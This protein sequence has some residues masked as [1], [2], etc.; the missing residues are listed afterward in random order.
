MCDLCL[1]NMVDS[2]HRWLPLLA[3]LLCLKLPTCFPF[4][5]PVR[6]RN[7][8]RT[9]LVA[10]RSIPENYWK[11]LG[12][13]PGS[14]VKEVK[15]IYRQRAKKEHPDVNKS[16][17]HWNVGVCCRMPMES[18]LIRCIVKN[19]KRSKRRKLKELRNEFA[20]AIPPTEGGQSHPHLRRPASKGKH[21]NGLQV[22]GI[23][24]VILCKKL[25]SFS[26]DLPMEMQMQVMLFESR[27]LLKKNFT[28]SKKNW[29]NCGRMKPNIWSLLNSSNAVVRRKKN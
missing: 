19:G 9:S 20:T 7:F 27:K 26:P 29:R 17:M 4:C 6:H 13:E 14:S 21:K 22:V 8:Q 11:V 16:P 24:S 28:N 25:R 10:Q 2:S 3:L 15:K 18:W 23:I 1:F 12:V 5:G